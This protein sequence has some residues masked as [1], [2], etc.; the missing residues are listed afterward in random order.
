MIQD[1][2][3]PNGVKFRKLSSME[4]EKSESVLQDMLYL[5]PKSRKNAFIF[6]L[7]ANM[8]ASN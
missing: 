2:A 8:D 6:T 4:P 1:F 7:D 5:I 3:F